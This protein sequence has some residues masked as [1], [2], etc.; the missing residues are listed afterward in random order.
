MLGIVGGSVIGVIAA[1][2]GAAGYLLGW[3][4]EHEV[5]CLFVELL[6]TVFAISFVD[7]ILT[8]TA[9][10]SPWAVTPS[11]LVLQEWMLPVLFLNCLFIWPAD[12]L[13]QFLLGKAS[14]MKLSW[15]V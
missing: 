8:G 14:M 3:W 15:R 1:A 2:Y 5:P 6:G 12:R 9:R 11:V 4:G 13:V 7:V 10:V